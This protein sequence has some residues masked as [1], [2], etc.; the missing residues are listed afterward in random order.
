M[1]TRELYKT[2]V[3]NFSHGCRYSH[4]AYLETLMTTISTFT[5]HTNVTRFNMSSPNWYLLEN[6][7]HNPK[8]SEKS[9]TQTSKCDR[10]KH[11]AVYMYC[12]YV[13]TFSLSQIQVFWDVPLCHWVGSSQHSEELWCCQNI[14]NSLPRDIAPHLRGH[15]SCTHSTI[16]SKDQCSLL[17]WSLKNKHGFV[18][19]PQHPGQQRWSRNM[20]YSPKKQKMQTNSVPM[21]WQP[22]GTH[23]LTVNTQC[24]TQHCSAWIQPI[25][26]NF[27]ACSG[28]K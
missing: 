14:R 3:Y 13:H 12:L 24:P 9:H 23:K 2:L 28:R 7:Q 17:A 4:N 11:T 6:S 19:S 1:Q 15:E 5:L 27:M 8:W 16:R 25:Q 20:S 21:F 22:F 10:M 26:H 18:K